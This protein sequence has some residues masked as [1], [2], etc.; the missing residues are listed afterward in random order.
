LKDS[1]WLW[2]QELVFA[3][4]LAVIVVMLR[5]ITGALSA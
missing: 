5:R 1:L 3:V 4:S 2:S